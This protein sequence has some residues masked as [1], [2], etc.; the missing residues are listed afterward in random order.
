MKLK[1]RVVI[2]TGASSGVGHAAA[3]LFAREGATVIAAARRRDRLD[4]LVAVIADAG[5]QAF[6]I[7]TDVTQSNQVQ[8][9][10]DR[11]VALLGRVDILINCAGGVLKVSGL[12]TFSDHEWRTILDTNVSGTFFA[13]RAVVPQMKRQGSG[14]I[15]NLSSRVG[16]TGVA[17]IAP[18]CAAKFAV[19]GLSQA[20]AAELRPHNIYV[21]TVFAGMIDSDIAPLRPTE[22]LRK[23]LMTVADVAETLLWACTLPP[24]L[25][26][27]ELS[28][29][30]RT[31]DL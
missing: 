15:I 13:S 24:S 30:P 27:D 18:F 9:L 19:A 28:V 23:K 12:E 16:K 25:R 5:G 22:D 31:V 29:S 2:I 10:I 11:T 17:N 21:T 4:H 6:A 1:G 20:L 7:P 8:Q 26:V 14:T 3:H